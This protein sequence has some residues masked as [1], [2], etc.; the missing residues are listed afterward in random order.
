MLLY[1]RLYSF[2]HCLCIAVA[3]LRR[4]GRASLYFYTVCCAPRSSH[5]MHASLCVI[6]CHPG[7]CCAQVWSYWLLILFFGLASVASIRARRRPRRQGRPVTPDTLEYWVRRA[8]CC[9]GMRCLNVSAASPLHRK[10]AGAVVHS[11]GFEDH[12]I[13]TWAVAASLA[14]GAGNV[15]CGGDDGS[16]RGF[17]GMAGADA[18]AVARA[19]V[20]RCTLAEA[21]LLL[22]RI[23]PGAC[24]CYCCCCTV[25]KLCSAVLTLSMAYQHL[26]DLSEHLMTA[27][28]VVVAWYKCTDDAGGDAAQPHPGENYSL[29]LLY[30]IAGT[31]VRVAQTFPLHAFV[32]GSA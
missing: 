30:N 22:D 7:V 17:G 2:F 25:L 12:C 6:E 1:F 24:C 31:R 26:P 10:G 21:V 5:A 28:D 8:A 15:P 20:A 18:H 19:P 13:L 29:A 16:D 11:C 14:P 32:A 27:G 3:Q 9:A 4:A 23:Q